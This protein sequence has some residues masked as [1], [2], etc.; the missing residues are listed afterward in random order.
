MFQKHKI[1]LDRPMDV[2]S[3][4]PNT[5]LLLHLAFEIQI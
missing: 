5:V 4:I 1:K 2:D 3:Y